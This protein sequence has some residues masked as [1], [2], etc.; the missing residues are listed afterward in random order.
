DGPRPPGPPPSAAARLWG[1]PPGTG[2]RAAGALVAWGIAAPVEPE[3]WQPTTR[4][5]VDSDVVWYLCG[6]PSWAS[7]WP[8]LERAAVPEACFHEELLEEMAASV[9]ALTGPEATSPVEVELTG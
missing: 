2:P 3:P 1:W 8:G 5:T 6:N 9:Q 4:W 7:F